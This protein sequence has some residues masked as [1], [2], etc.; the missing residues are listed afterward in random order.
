MRLIHTSDWHLGR[1]LFDA[2]LLE[3]QGEFLA[4]LLAAALEHRVG[5]VLVAGDVYDRAVPPPEAVHLLDHT[6][7]EFSRAGVAL[8]LTAGNH[9]SAVRLGFGGAL[10]EAA[11]VH[12]RTRVADL[13]RP[14]VAHRRARP[15]RRATASPTCSPT[16]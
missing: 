4:W 15:R 3:H 12:L 7:A 5:A 9:D 8:L 16:R 1:R 13:D 6:L 10:T 11:G 2:D 14:V